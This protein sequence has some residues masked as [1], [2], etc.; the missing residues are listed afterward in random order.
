MYKYLALGDS[1][2]IGEQVEKTESFP[3]QTVE[4]L[5]KEQDQPI[6][7]PV[8]VAKTGWTTDELLHAIEKE[9]LSGEFSWVSLLIG[10]N[11]QYRSYGMEQYTNEFTILLQKAISFARGRNE[12][13][14]VLSIPDWG[15]TP[16]AEGKDRAKIAIEI[17]EYNSINKRISQEYLCPYL[18]ITESTRSFGSDKLFLTPD[19]LHYSGPLYAKWAKLLAP[20]ISTIL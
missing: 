14:F 4:L 13:V 10:V 6:A 3:F 20:L 15:V 18:D 8:I 7:D 1:Y 9:S 17:D 12:R 16:Y 11:N 19:L 2:T 5:R